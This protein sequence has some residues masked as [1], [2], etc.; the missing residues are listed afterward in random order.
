MN[1]DELRDMARE[2]GLSG[3]HDM[4]KEELIDVP[5]GKRSS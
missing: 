3:V 1:V 4:R 2:T 5:S